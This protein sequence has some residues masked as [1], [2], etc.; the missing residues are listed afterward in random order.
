MGAPGPRGSVVGAALVVLGV[1]A[2]VGAGAFAYQRATAEQ[3]V[4]ARAR[5]TAQGLTVA[6]ATM[7]RDLAR[8]A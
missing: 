8:R 4:G 5:E 6:L 2:L 7:K 1:A 3:A